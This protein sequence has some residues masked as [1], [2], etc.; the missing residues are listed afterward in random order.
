MENRIIA[1]Q[2]LLIC[3]F[4][5]DYLA[6]FNPR[7]DF[8]QSP[9]SSSAGSAIASAACPWLDFAL[10]TDT[11]GSTR[12]PA[13]VCGTYGMRPSTNI[14]ST[15]GM[16][17]V[18]P[19]LDSIG[20]FARSAFVVEAVVKTLIKPSYPSSVPSQLP[21]TYKLLYPI[22]AKN[23]KLQDSLCWFP[24]PGQPG[25]AA[26][27]ENLFENTVQKFESHFNC[28]RSPFDLD[29]M[30]RQSRPD[31]QDESLDKATGGTYTV[32]TTY[33]SVRET[34]DAFIAD[35]KNANN[36]RSPFI[37]SIVKA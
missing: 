2:R 25:H 33:P 6:P 27:V 22:R 4:R 37:D 3:F 14:I 19:L 5:T 17:S 34:I 31:G 32:L 13:G 28:T 15:A 35:F 8:Y 20:I 18:S 7:G 10:G 12:H 1:G 30:W 29:D 23:T 26:D 21:V 24:Y 16:Y 9:S 36:G 11:G